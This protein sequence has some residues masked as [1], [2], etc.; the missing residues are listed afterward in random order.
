MLERGDEFITDLE[1]TQS[2]QKWYIRTV[3]IE[4]LGRETDDAQ[5]AFYICIVLWFCLNVLGSSIIRMG[6][7]GSI[8][9]C[10]VLGWFILVIDQH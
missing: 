8:V 2:E 5:S 1:T 3:N 6:Q 7:I 10:S 9:D 4:G